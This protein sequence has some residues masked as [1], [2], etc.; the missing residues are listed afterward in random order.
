MKD[1]VNTTEQVAAFF[2]TQ[3][4]REG[5]FLLRR[6]LE[7]RPRGWVLVVQCVTREDGSQLK[8]QVAEAEFWLPSQEAAVRCRDAFTHQRLPGGITT[9]AGVVV[10]SE[11]YFQCSFCE[12]PRREVGR[13]FRSEVDATVSVCAPCIS[14]L[15]GR[16]SEKP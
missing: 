15:A 7:H 8:T 4:E 3:V 1:V 10:P 16:V 13:L 11:K 5:G 14:R 9:L 2:I 12:L 6:D